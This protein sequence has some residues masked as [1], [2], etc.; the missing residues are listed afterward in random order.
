MLFITGEYPPMQ[1]GVGAYTA[2]LAK[3][4][5][6]QGS[7][8][9]VLTSR[10]AAAPPPGVTVYPLVTTWN[11]RIWSQ[12]LHVAR[13]MGA[14]WLHVQ[15]QT[16]A[17]AMH[18]AINFAPWWW[19]R[20]GMRVAF[21][22]H[23]LLPPYLFPK[24]GSKLRH[25]VTTRPA[26]LSD[27]TVVTNQADHDR[28]A[29]ELSAHIPHLAHIPIGSNIAPRD[30]DA[31]ARRATRAAW[32][33]DNATLLLGY[34]GFLNRSKGGLVLVEALSQIMARRP[35]TKLLMIGERVGASDPTNFA[36]L[37]EV[38][39]AIA[40]LGLGD[41]IAWTGNL[42]DA[43]VSACLDACD[44]VVLPYLD[45]ASTRRGTLMAALA[46]GCAVVTTTPLTPLPALT[47]GVS[48]ALVAPNDAAATADAV[49]HIAAQPRLAE[50]LR[51]GARQAA[52]AFTWEG[53][54]AA[55]VR[56]YH[57]A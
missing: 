43:A 52:A 49:L 32:G 23:D 22:Y 38:E 21:T 57:A 33:A 54:A 18:P 14:T 47:D 10:A 25:W 2:E 15:Y 5:V 56:C 51:R 9:G 42:P 48:V 16:A 31:A 41:H 45:G 39:T 55:H 6:A 30:F 50:Q 17:Y 12:A 40:R 53:I 28:L 37:Q 20:N 3:A 34:F 7:A 13:Q 11:W 8:V 4:L 1:G 35:A 19:R 24:A 27:L 44:V 36:Y 26:L 46:Q 29:R